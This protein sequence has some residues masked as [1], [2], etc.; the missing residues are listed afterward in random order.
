MNEELSLI[1]FNDKAEEI[2]LRK[3][4]KDIKINEIPTL[5]AKGG[6]NFYLGIKKAI[7]ALRQTN[8]DV[9]PVLIFMTDGEVN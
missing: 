8:D 4:I 7:F 2:Y 5:R 9:T 3:Q 6:T 1:L